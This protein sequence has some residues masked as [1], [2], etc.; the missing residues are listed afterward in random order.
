M[1]LLE[2]YAS[3]VNLQIGK[4]HLEEQFFA[5]P[6]SRYITLH[7]GSGMP[8]KNYP[9][10]AEVIHL[11]KPYLSA[12]NIE[13]VQIGV[14][15]DVAVAGC[16][17]TMGQTTKH[18]ANYLVGRSMLHLANDSIWAHRVGYLGIPLVELFATTSV[19]NHSPYQFDAAKT[20]FISSH[21]WGKN[22]TFAS[23]EAP[24]T[25]LLIDPFLVARSV[26]DLL[27]ISHTIAQRSLQVGHTYN[28]PILDWIPNVGVAPSFNPDLPL[29]A[30]M[31]IHHD[32]AILGATL[33]TGRRVNIVTKAPVSLEIL[34]AFKGSIQSF[35]YEVSE[36][37]PLDYVL[38]L[39]KV[40][41]CLTFFTRTKDEAELSRIRFKFFDIVN[42]Q[43]LPNKTRADFE[44]ESAEYQNRPLE[45][46]KIELDQLIKS[47]MLKFKTNKFVLSKGKMFLSLAHA[48]ADIPMEGNNQIGTVL[49]DG[50]FWRDLNHW[51]VYV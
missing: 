51:L 3:F 16:H 14:K 12:A 19:E 43:Q 9:M 50:E 20:R 27:G 8:G 37:T 28:A 41:Q 46:V 15:E 21:R 18:Q 34:A 30:R 1:K 47:G 6:F 45:D 35:N 7:A 40:L 36:S 10:F 23:Q 29:A 32:D 13:I 2:R 33:Q 4:Q 48:A 5:L 42:V 22:P 39:K 44:K 24:S 26:L 11:I 31:D 38:K 25:A 49:D 17:H